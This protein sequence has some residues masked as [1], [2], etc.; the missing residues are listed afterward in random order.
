MAELF[1]SE[2][3]SDDLDEIYKLRKTASR[4]QSDWRQ[5]ARNAFE[6]R[7]GEQW[8]DA[9]KAILEEQ[10][11]PVVVFNRVAPII[12]SIVGYEISNRQEVRYLPRT[13]GDRKIN[14]IY[15]EAARWVRDNCDAEDEETDA[16][17]DAITCGMGWTE[18]RVDYDEDPKG[19]LVKER[20]PP[21]EMRWD[22]NA[23]KNNLADADWMMREKWWELSAVQQRWPD[24][25]G[26]IRPVQDTEYDNW[27]DEHDATN[28][29]KYHHDQRWFDPTE[30]KVLVIQYQYREKEP[31]YIVADPESGRTV[32]FS[33]TRWNRIK[34]KVSL[35]AVKMNKWVYKQKFIAGHTVLEEGDAPI[36]GFSFHC[37]TGK[38]DEE[39]ATW[40]GLVRVMMDPQKWANAFFSQAMFVLQANSKGGVIVEEGAVSEKRDFED[41]WSSPDGVIYVEDG[42]LQG[43]RITEKSMGGYPP[44][45]DK[46]MQ[47]AISSIRDCAGVNLEMLGSA[48]HEQPGILEVERKKAALVILA[49]ITNSLRRYRKISGRALLAFMRRYIPPG[50]IM[51]IADQPVPFWADDDVVEYDVIV[52]TAPNSPNLK[53]EVWAVMQNIVPAMVKA[54]VPLPPDLIKF[55][56]L[57]ESI[58]DEWV[59]YINQ[60]QGMPDVEGMNQ[61]M[62][63]MQKE[64]Q[65]LSEE[66]ATLNDKT[67]SRMMDLEY[68]AREAQLDAQIREKE[69][70]LKAQMQEQELIFRMKMSDAD[71]AA[72]LI[73]INARYETELEKIR[74]QGMLQRETSQQQIE[75]QRE[76]QVISLEAER[77]KRAAERDI[78]VADMVNPYIDRVDHTE[79]LVEQVAEDFSAYRKAEEERRKIILDFIKSRGGEIAEV[80]ERLS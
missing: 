56:P 30:N 60:R 34:D 29:W 75:S 13:I 64:I 68:K 37:I 48:G 11:R 36:D 42:A 14:S 33:E 70:V 19:Q 77:Q 28:A 67:K 50:T 45:L 62:A 65:R 18:W 59:E 63:E 3:L 38:R 21:L 61:Q 5:E 54:G 55:S 53:Q 40:Y 46:L 74:A 71:R 26:D 57:P 72:K 9:D 10:R 79:Q 41:R 6:F 47:F 32:E 43:G 17:G 20:V 51:R 4:H 78:K 25:A 35:E 44:A 73:E 8:D 2:Y 66:N 23:R 31:Y 80:A 69:M 58:A 39:H 15:T 22:P 76:L 12:D 7:D 16:F 24:K 27:L 49:P 1:E 52:D